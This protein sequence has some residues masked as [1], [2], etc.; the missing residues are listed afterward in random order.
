MKLHRPLPTKTRKKGI[1][2][3][4]FLIISVT[5]IIIKAV[6]YS[7]TDK[8][9]III[10]SAE[11]TVKGEQVS[12]SLPLS[13]SGLAHRT[14]VRVA[15]DTPV[16]KND[17]MFFGSVYA[18]L[19][20]Y[21]NGSLIY[22]YGQDGTYPSFMKDLPTHYDSVILHCDEETAHI[23][24][25]YLSPNERDT[26]SVHEPMVGS[27]KAIFRHLFLRC[28]LSLVMSLF[29]ILFGTV[30]SVMSLAFVKTD[31]LGLAMIYPG[32]FSIMA[33]MWQPGE[34]TL[35]VYLLQMPSLLYFVDFPGLFLLMIPM[36][37]TAIFHLE[38]EG[39]ILLESVLCVIEAAD[40]AAIIL[41]LT[42]KVSFHRS[43]FAFHIILPLTMLL[44]FGYSLLEAIRFRSK[45]AQRF[46]IPFLVLSLS[47]VLELLNYYLNFVRIYSSIFQ[48]GV[49][50]FTIILLALSVMYITDLL[51]DQRKKAEL[52]GELRIRDQIL[53]YQK[54]RLEMLISMSDEIRKQRH[55]LRHHL[56]VIDDMI[57]KKHL[58]EAK[59][60]IS[61]VTDTIPTYPTKEWCKNSVVNSTIGYYAQLAEDAHIRLDVFVELPAFNPNISDISLCVIFGN[62]LENAIEACHVMRPESRYIK[63]CSKVNGAMLFISMDNS[64]NGV[65]HIKDG[66]FLSSKRQGPVTGLHSVRSLAESHDGSAEFKTTE[67][68]FRSEV[69]LR[70]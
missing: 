41:Q 61:N 49:F 25:V 64:F 24:M 29:F 51:R 54:S 16:R 2:V 32:L 43:L 44:L 50:G 34:N 67:N 59:S 56:H 63:L 60:Y 20:V 10:K 6:P 5:F 68:R 18:P 12:D 14:E 11:I 42:G 62:L 33:G 66:E 35:S 7:L 8:D 22:E 26:L 52:E 19:K 28:G 69:C 45:N 46:M 13:Q 40:A 65:V 27:R 58:S 48:I 1:A 21:A 47:T 4:A 17:L 15:F 3:V 53:S 55:D 57:E 39:D 38:K 30:L 36:Y 9:N 37:R 31:D 23:E 70:L